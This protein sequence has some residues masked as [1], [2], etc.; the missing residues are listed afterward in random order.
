MIK[1]FRKTQ[2]E[3]QEEAAREY[4]EE[5][6]EEAAKQGISTEALYTS[7][8]PAK[9]VL[10]AIDKYS[11]ELVVVEKLRE[12]LFELFLGDEIDYLCRKAPCEV[13][14]VS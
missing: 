14:T 1:T 7:G 10:E 13:L 5:V 9:E 2:R 8:D 3:V 4:A 6:K 11:I 12:R